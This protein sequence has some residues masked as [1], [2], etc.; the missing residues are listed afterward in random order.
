MDVIAVAH[1]RQMLHNDAM[2]TAA[3]YRA[4][5]RAVATAYVDEVNSRT[6]CSRCGAQPVEWHHP[7]HPSEPNARVSSLRTQGAS[8]ERIQR[9]IERCTPLCR[10][11]HMEE[12]GR[13]DALRGAGPR[14]KGQVYVE[15]SPCDDCGRPTKPTRRGRCN[16]CYLKFMGIR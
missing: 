13:M 11:C 8:V 2:P 1:R 6:V 12:D 10:T 16:H 9:E 7:D 14:K 15:P 5:R 3:E 4:R